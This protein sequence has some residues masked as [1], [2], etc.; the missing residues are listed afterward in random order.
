M[1]HPAIPPLN[2]CI[3]PK[4][5]SVMSTNQS[6]MFLNGNKQKQR[7]GKFP[8][9]YRKGNMYSKRLEPGVGNAGCVPNF[10]TTD[11]SPGLEADTNQQ[12][13][14][15]TNFV[16]QTAAAAV[17]SHNVAAPVIEV[18][19][20]ADLNQLGVQKAIEELIA[21]NKSF[22]NYQNTQAKTTNRVLY[23][24]LEKVF[25]LYAK[26]KEKGSYA[27]QLCKDLDK[28]A[29]DAGLTFGAKTT[30]LS[31]IL[32]CVFGKGHK[33]THGYYTVIKFAYEHGC[34]P[35]E[36]V[37]FIEGFGGI[38]KIREAAHAQNKKQAGQQPAPTRDQK[39]AN[40]RGQISASNVCVIEDF[41]LKQLIPQ[42]CFD[43]QILLVAT[44]KS[45]GTVEINAAVV[46]NDAVE[47]ALLAYA[48]AK[49][50]AEKANKADDD[51]SNAAE[52]PSAEAK[53]DMAEMTA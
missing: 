20:F 44:P 14:V 1:R 17:A 41:E 45:D 39:L 25:A 35:H 50:K 19:K 42:G 23:Q 27:E 11:V 10:A 28:Y 32:G 15:P 26:M 2:S 31:K 47:K 51:G 9:K 29:I 34:M 24:L 37:E 49:A 13:N 7:I 5:E 18:T 38:Q 43:K 40:A 22:E 21:D 52:E 33:K 30:L 12:I 48:A 46:D 8:R 4:Q 16:Q 36:L 53:E 6:T 3:D